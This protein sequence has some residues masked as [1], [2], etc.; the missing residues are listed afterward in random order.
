[1]FHMIVA[2]TISTSYFL[3]ELDFI[4]LVYIIHFLHPSNTPS[5]DVNSCNII[6]LR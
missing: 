6:Y 1:M 4:F 5:E 2:I 3:D